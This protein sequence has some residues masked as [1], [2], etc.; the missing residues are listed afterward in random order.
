MKIQ[1]TQQRSLK[2]LNPLYYSEV[3][4]ASA[5][6][7]ATPR[8]R[9]MH[10]CLGDETRTIITRSGGIRIGYDPR[11]LD[12]VRGKPI[13]RR[14]EHALRDLAQAGVIR[15]SDADFPHWL[16]WRKVEEGAM[17]S[18]ADAIVDE[19]ATLQMLS[20]TSDA[21]HAALRHLV[22]KHPTE[23][24]LGD[25]ET[26]FA[27]LRKPG[28][29]L[30]S[31][32]S[33][34]HF[35]EQ[36]QKLAFWQH[37]GLPRAV[38]HFHPLQFIYHMRRALW[39][40]ADELRQAVPARVLRGIGA[41]IPDKIVYESSLP[42]SGQLVALHK[43]ILNAVWKKY[44]VTTRT[45]LAAFLGNSVQETGWLR[46][47]IEDN[48]LGKW[49]APWYGRGFLQLTHPANYI[50]YWK[51]RGLS[52][53]HAVKRQLA[54]SHAQADE[55][56]SNIPLHE[57]EANLP[58]LVTKW[59]ND[60]A[61]KP[62]EAADS[63][64]YYWLRN[65]ANE[66]A[67]KDTASA[68]RTFNVHFSSPLKKRELFVF[69]E[70]V[71]FRRVACIVNLPDIWKRRSHHSTAWLIATTLTPMHKCCCQTNPPSP[72]RRERCSSSRRITHGR[73]NR[74]TLA[75]NRETDSSACLAGRCLQRKCW[76]GGGRTPSKRHAALHNSDERLRYRVHGQD[77]RIH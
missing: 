22:V 48:P 24:D 67:D 61:E 10:L 33:W 65:R 3:V 51:F 64:G 63:A 18:A 16:G 75:S 40:S 5:T 17:L 74:T 50:A 28:A 62:F 23:W 46:A 47:A 55:L 35:K 30:V 4:I 45:R 41:G 29:H 49:Y 60:I 43:N 11:E 39:L 54:N 77:R 73:S 21:G 38:W 26:R 6:A 59:R 8:R 56:R 53:A 27:R 66:E 70:N 9:D 31:D 42:K 37:T 76:C 7:V 58:A 36:A 68:R 72:T 25:L 52:I 69:Y 57:I 14:S 19:P 34:R 2:D 12:E 44:G 13:L 15:L 32:E 1:D 71:S 20:D